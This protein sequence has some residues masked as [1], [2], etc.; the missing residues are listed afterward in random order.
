MWFEIILFMKNKMLLRFIIYLHPRVLN[1][2]EYTIGRRE[3]ILTLRHH[4]PFT[5]FGSKNL[6]PGFHCWPPER[7]LNL[8]NQ[9]K[10][11]FRC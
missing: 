10:F 8:I 1:E 5:M 4:V 7:I 11:H 2:N 9:L 6:V 3:A